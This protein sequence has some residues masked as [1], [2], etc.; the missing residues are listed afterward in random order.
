MRLTVRLG[1]Q[2]AQVNNITSSWDRSLVRS[3]GYA[4]VGGA[5][6]S[7]LFTYAAEADSKSETSS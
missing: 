4:T 1:A 2:G 5:T 6:R 3:N 7:P